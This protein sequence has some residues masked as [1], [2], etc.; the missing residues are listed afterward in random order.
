MVMSPPPPRST[1]PET[2]RPP[3]LPLRSRVQMIARG[4][5]IAAMESANASKGFLVRTVAWARARVGAVRSKI[6][7]VNAVPPA[8]SLNAPAPLAGL[9]ATAPSPCAL[10][11][12]VGTVFA[13]KST[14]STS[15][16]AN[17][18]GAAPIATPQLART[19]AVGME[20]A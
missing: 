12:A 3:R 4:T 2:E 9:G 8:H 13:C 19:S 6:V 15:A 14:E 7:M 5:A 20:N 17:R 11:T 16:T 1:V 18:D 10:T